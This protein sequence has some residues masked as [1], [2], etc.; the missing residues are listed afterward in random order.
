MRNDTTNQP[1]L[2]PTAEPVNPP[3]T[4]S[5]LSQLVYTPQEL[6]PLLRLSKNTVNKLLNSGQLRAV[7]CGRKWLIP[8]GAIL[9]Y[10]A[11][12]VQS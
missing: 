4:N 2:N 8:Q 7:R 3:A 6:E 10:L 5:T 9:E 12:G 11:G 1:A